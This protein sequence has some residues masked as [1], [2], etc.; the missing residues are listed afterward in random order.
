MEVCY[1]VRCAFTD[2]RVAKR[3]VE[4]LH[5]GHLQDVLD[6]G[7]TSARVVRIRGTG[8]VF[9]ARYTFASAED[10]ARYERE[11]APRLRA[12]GLEAFPLSL[13]LEYSR[14]VSDAV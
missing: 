3:W 11:E 13:G 5:A 4:W 1:D 10:F 9:E 7:A 14:T 6:A 2:P 12:L 8:P